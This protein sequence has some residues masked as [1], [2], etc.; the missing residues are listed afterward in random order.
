MTGLPAAFRAFALASTAR[1]ADSVIAAIRREM[2]RCAGG[3]SDWAAGSVEETAVMGA[4]VSKTTPGALASTRPGGRWL[5]GDPVPYTGSPGA[6]DP[7]TGVPRIHIC[8]P[9]LPRRGERSQALGGAL[10][11]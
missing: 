4:M 11:V 10:G 9:A 7:A 1:V 8:G 5:I 2:R 6:A 3:R